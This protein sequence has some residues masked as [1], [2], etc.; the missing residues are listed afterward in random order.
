MKHILTATLIGYTAA[1]TA[2]TTTATTTTTTAAAPTFVDSLPQTKNLTD[3]QQRV[4][5][6]FTWFTRQQTSADGKTVT[7]HVFT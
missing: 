2:T 3:E 5:G 6:T 1:Q 4:V 7:N